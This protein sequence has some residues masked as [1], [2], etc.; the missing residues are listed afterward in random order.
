[1]LPLPVALPLP[2]APDDDGLAEPPSSLNVLAVPHPSRAV[3]EATT[4]TALDDPRF[5]MHGSPAVGHSAN[6]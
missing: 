1:M 6:G 3:N 5:L 2:P 4:T